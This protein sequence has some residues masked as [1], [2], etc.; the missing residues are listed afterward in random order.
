MIFVEIKTTL[1]YFIL[2]STHTILSK[3]QNRKKN[4]LPLRY[5]KGHKKV[6]H[7]PYKQGALWWFEFVISSDWNLWIKGM[8]GEAIEKGADIWSFW[9]NY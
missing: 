1:E 4:G 8:D 2:P 9:I 7:P 6:V 5:K 3:I